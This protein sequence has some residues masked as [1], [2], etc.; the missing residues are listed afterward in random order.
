MTLEKNTNSGIYYHSEVDRFMVSAVTKDML[1]AGSL[2]E[3][4]V[5][6]GS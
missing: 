3:L 5:Q 1:L 4:L 2:F 6:L